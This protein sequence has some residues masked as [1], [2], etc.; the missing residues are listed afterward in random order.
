MQLAQPDFVAWEGFFSTLGE[1]S[2][3]L[4]GLLFV[5][6]SVGSGIYTRERQY[7]LRVFLSPTVVHFSSVLLSCLVMLAPHHAGR[8]AG[9]P[10][11]AGSASGIF[12]AALVLRRMARH[13]IL[14]KID[15]EDRLW[16]AAM[17]GL[18]YLVI[19]GA[20]VT[21][22]TDEGDA[23]GITAASLCLLLIIGLR[24]AWDITSWT[25]LRRSEGRDPP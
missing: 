17:P 14:D 13:G 15:G 25:V 18:A 8:G 22:V 3:T 11:L 6:A 23:C 21:L 16:Y 4:V 1:S 20:G 2:A 10:I 24:N 12:Y 9:V 5:G 19:G 7:A